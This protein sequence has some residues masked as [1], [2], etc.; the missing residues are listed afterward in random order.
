MY[1]ALQR[2]DREHG[3][4]V[5]LLQEVEPTAT[6]TRTSGLHVGLL[7]DGTRYGRIQKS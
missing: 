2:R 3:P 5:W 7:F 6:S 4:N 1:R